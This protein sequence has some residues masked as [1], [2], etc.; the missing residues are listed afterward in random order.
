MCKSFPFGVFDSIQHLWRYRYIC[1]SHLFIAFVL[2]YE[3]LLPAWNVPIESEIMPFLL[4]FEVRYQRHMSVE[5]LLQCGQLCT[6]RVARSGYICSFRFF[7]SSSLSLSLYSYACLIFRGIT[8]ECFFSI[9]RLSSCNARNMGVR[10]NRQQKKPDI[11]TFTNLL[12]ALTK[13]VL[14]WWLSLVY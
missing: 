12:P 2:V 11:S 9:A 8:V 3:K 14:F 5:R 1:E 7:F 13:S 6:W 10:C 4:A